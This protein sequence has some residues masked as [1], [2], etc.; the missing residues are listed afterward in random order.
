MTA[1]DKSKSEGDD[2]KEDD[3][4]NDDDDDQGVSVGMCADGSLCLWFMLEAADAF[5]V[6]MEWDKAMTRRRRVGG[7]IVRGRS[8]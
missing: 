3:N 5:I 4:G 8:R 6:I 1:Y 7:A 2:S